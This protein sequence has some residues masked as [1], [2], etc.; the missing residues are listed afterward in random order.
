MFVD[1]VEH[2]EVARRIQLSGSHF[3]FLVLD[4]KAY[5][6]AVFEGRDL[7]EL[8][9]ASRGEGWR[10]PRLCHITRDAPDLGL[11]IQPVEGEKGKFTV[12]P[13]KGGAAEKAGVKKGDRL[14]WIDGAMVS[15]LPHSA[16]SK[17]VKKCKSHMTVLVIESDS[18]KSYAHR[19]MPILP[20]MADAE[21]MPYRPRRLHLAMG[22]EG[23]GFLLRQ[24]KA[25]AGRTVHMVREVDEGSP[26]ER[27]SVKDGEMLLEV[28]GKPTESLSH[29]QVVSQ[30]RESGQQ[31]TLTTMPPQGQDF[32]TK[33]GLSHLLF[34]V[35]VASGSPE[36]P[37]EIPVTLKSAVPSVATQEDVQINPNVRRCILERG[38]DG[39]GFHLGCVQQKPGTFISQLAAGGPGQSSGLLQGDVVVDV[40]GKNVEKESVEEVTLHVKKGGDTLS[41]LVV[42]QKSYDWLKKNGKPITVNKLAPISEVDEN[43]SSAAEPPTLKTDDLSDDSTSEDEQ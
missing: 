13:V 32:Y 4:D 35:D 33:L 36:E 22:P 20:A 26:A 39:F 30:I 27:G 29:A 24:E 25:G 6:Q 41:L 9:E 10:P 15:E 16:V 38:S 11:N 42:D 5:E 28:N 40:N 31:V 8:A 2:T 43:V 12:S 7:K 23:Y 17:L 3:C 37:K 1:N 14:I 21:N 19:K 34:C 18:A